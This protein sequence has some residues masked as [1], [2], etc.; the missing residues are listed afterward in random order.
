M[1]IP[2]VIV[3]V[4]S[5]RVLGRVAFGVAL[6]V[7]IAGGAAAGLIFVYQSD[8]PEVRA[9]EDY[10]PNVVTELYGDEGELIGTFAL[11]RR[12]LLTSAQ[13]PRVLRDAILVTED[14]HFD[15]HWGVDLPRAVQAAWRNVRKSH[16]TPSSPKSRDAGRLFGRCARLS[17]LLDPFDGLVA[18]HGTASTRLLDPREGGA[19]P[20]P[21]YPTPSAPSSIR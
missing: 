17:S 2:R 12:I 1:R 5:A 11:Q 8:L 4:A 20:A 9:L 14:R 10:R 13:V 3:Q 15:E 6:L 18:V 19:H 21:G 16:R 7:A